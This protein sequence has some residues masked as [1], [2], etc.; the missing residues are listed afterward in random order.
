MAAED[1]PVKVVDGLAGGRPDV[2][3]DSVVLEPGLASGVAHE[4]EHAA[5]LLRREL[6]DV[7]ER[8]D[9]PLG[10][11]EQMCV[12][13][14]VDVADGDEPLGGVDVVAL[15]EEPAEEAV[16]RQRGRPLP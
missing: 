8:L 7:A 13:L 16:V 5:C 9:V 10:D 14:R 3:D 1:V 11:D 2:D 4:G 6:A 12:R 15:A